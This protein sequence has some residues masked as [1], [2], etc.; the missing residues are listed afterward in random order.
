MSCEIELK[1]HAEDPEAVKKRLSRLG[2]W[3]GSYTKEDCYWKADAGNSALPA[4]G[5]RVR[6]ESRKLPDGTIDDAAC[7][8]TFKTKEKRDGIEV[9][10][11]NEFSV[12]DGDTFSALLPRLGLHEDYR[13]RKTGE[14]WI[15]DGDITAE[16]AEVSDSRRSLGVFLELEIIADNDSPATVKA[17]RARLL[18]LLAACGLPEHRIEPRYYAEMLSGNEQ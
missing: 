6:H 11:E 3:G 16:L 12:S 15:A 5:L 1:A 10:E 13:K 2:V 4:S 14:V 17:A 9:N 7:I 18:A 8:V